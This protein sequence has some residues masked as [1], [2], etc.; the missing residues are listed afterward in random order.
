M[1]RFPLIKELECIYKGVD[2]PAYQSHCYA[3]ENSDKF[4][5]VPAYVLALHVSKNPLFLCVF[6][7]V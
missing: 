5:E 4:A 6:A 2:I 7:C 3:Y 1:V